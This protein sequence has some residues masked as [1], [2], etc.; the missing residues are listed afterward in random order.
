MRSAS[1]QSRVADP[2]HK[3]PY[4]DPGLNPKVFFLNSEQNPRKMFFCLIRVKKKGIRE[5]VL[6]I[7]SFKNCENFL[8]IEKSYLLKILSLLIQI[9]GP[10]SDP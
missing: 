3:L 7:F 4:S 10:D 5:F 1:R 2:A 6:L 8:N 9:H